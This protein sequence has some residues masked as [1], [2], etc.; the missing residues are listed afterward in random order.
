MYAMLGTRPDLCHA[1][2]YF[3]RYQC[4]PTEQ[5][6]VHLK[7]VLRYIKGSLDY[8]LC[9]KKNMNMPQILSAYIDADWGNDINDR[10][11]TTGYL[12]KL[13][14]C[15]ISWCSRKQQTVAIS[16][17]ESEYMAVS[18][19][20]CEILWIRSLISFL[21]LDVS[22]PTLLYEDN[23]S[24]I[25]LTSNSEYHKRTKHID[26]KHHYI[27]EK[28]KDGTVQLKYI[29]TT[30]QEA[31]MLTKSLPTSKFKNNLLKIGLH[32]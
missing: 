3:S 20:I 21:N 11:S 14:G 25:K 26:I 6:R 9:Y 7:R 30:D 2:S 13:Y 19:A 17:T 23:Q 32:I 15:T 18:D 24:C 16:S 22:E 1:V 5:H 27:R 12:L 10:R 28:V 4:H 8:K 31:D 29:H